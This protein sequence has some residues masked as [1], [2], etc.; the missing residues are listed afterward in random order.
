MKNDTRGLYRFLDA[1][2]MTE[3][4]AMQ[5]AVQRHLKAM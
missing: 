5:K 2:P 1:T 4:K 3:I